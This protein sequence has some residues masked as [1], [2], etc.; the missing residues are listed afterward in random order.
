MSQENVEGRLD[1]S[2][3]VFNPGVDEGVEG[4]RRMFEGVLDIWQEFELTPK[5]FVEAP[6]EGGGQLAQIP[7]WARLQLARPRIRAA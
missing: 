2:H 6:R 3:N 4:L 7:R 1:V 5:E